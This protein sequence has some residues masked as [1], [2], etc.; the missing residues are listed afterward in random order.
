MHAHTEIYYELTKIKE[1]DYTMHILN[2]LSEF[3]WHVFSNYKYIT[4]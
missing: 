3:D 2:R 1:I 4:I